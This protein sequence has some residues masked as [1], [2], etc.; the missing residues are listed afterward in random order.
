MTESHHLTHSSFQMMF[1]LL[2]NV[3]SHTAAMINTIHHPK[4]KTGDI[5]LQHL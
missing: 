1:P 5:N 3:N 2:S 4:L